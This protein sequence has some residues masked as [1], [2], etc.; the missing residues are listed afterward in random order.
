MYVCNTKELLFEMQFAICPLI[1]NI[2]YICLSVFA[3]LWLEPTSLIF[4]SKINW[5]AGDSI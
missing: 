2:L 3:L 4:S 5:T 1:K